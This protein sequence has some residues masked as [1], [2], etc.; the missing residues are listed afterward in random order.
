MV[1]QKISDNAM[2]KVAIDFRVYLGN[3]FSISQTKSYNGM[4]QS[5]PKFSQL[6]FGMIYK[7]QLIRNIVHFYEKLRNKN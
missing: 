1:K 4:E 5:M 2:E 6:L 3:V 7:K